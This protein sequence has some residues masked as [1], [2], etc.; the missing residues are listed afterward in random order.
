M[1]A[2]SKS[3]AGR[4]YMARFAPSMIA[5]VIAIMAASYLTS[6]EL[7]DGWMLYAVAVAPALGILGAIWAMGM[8]VVEETDE[9]VRMKLV[10]AMMAATAVTLSAATVWGFLEQFSDVA[11]IPAY[12]A[13]I[14][15]CASMGLAQLWFK[16]TGQ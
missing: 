16:V 13:F 6:R 12:Y 11:H 7:V 2:N 14:L 10:R 1:V 4:R 9:Y 8:Y 15:W 5:Y 3:P